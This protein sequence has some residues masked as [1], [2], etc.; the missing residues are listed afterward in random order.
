MH[1]FGFAALWGYKHTALG[2]QSGS[3]GKREISATAE[4][5]LI[6]TEPAVAACE[7]CAHCESPSVLAFL[8]LCVMDVSDIYVWVA[9]PQSWLPG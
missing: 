9:Q 3:V 5:A 4:M 1:G 6:P 7:G 8:A 2:L